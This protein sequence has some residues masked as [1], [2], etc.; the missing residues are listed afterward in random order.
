MP[1]APMPNG[2]TARAIGL[3]RADDADASRRPG[4]RIVLAH[5]ERRLRRKRLRTEGGEDILVDFPD[6]MTLADRDRLALDDAREVEVAAA[7]ERLLEV[8]AADARALAAMAWQIGNRHLSAQIEAD[9]IL[10]LHDHV[11]ASMLE[12]LGAQVREVTAPFIPESGAY[13]GHRHTGHAHE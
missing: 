2:G 7:T 4:D 3:V 10:V 1:T 11:I 13:G 9:R 6:P 12:G 5:D 8:R